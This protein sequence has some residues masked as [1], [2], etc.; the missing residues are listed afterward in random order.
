L[1]QNIDFSNYE[2]NELKKYLKKFNFLKTNNYFLK[3]IIYKEHKLIESSE[4][5]EEK[6]EEEEN[7]SNSDSETE[8]SIKKFDIYDQNSISIEKNMISKTKNTMTENRFVVCSKKTNKW[9]IKI[10]I[11]TGWFGC[12]IANFDF[13]NK[14]NLKWNMLAPNCLLLIVLFSTKKGKICDE[15]GVKENSDFIIEEGDILQFEINKKTLKI[16]CKAKKFSVK[17]NFQMKNP[18]PCLNIKNQSTKV[19]FY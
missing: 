15:K 17:K 10:I 6:E 19:K 12:G 5:E 11:M 13:I 9:K 1:I 7:N 8:K 4:E 14:G 2:I 18:R 3:Q 16:S